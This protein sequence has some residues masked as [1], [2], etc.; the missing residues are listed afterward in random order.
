MKLLLSLLILSIMNW[1]NP[2]TLSLENWVS[3]LRMNHPQTKRV[4]AVISLLSDGLGR[5]DGTW[6]VKF[7]EQTISVQKLYYS[8]KQYNII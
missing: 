7:V 1:K 3:N 2:E 5:M 6:I 4:L 8:S